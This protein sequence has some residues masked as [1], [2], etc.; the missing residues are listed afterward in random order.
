MTTKHIT[1][2]DG[3]GGGATS[4]FIKAEILSRFGNSYLNSLE[5]SSWLPE[6]HFP[7]V[8]TTDSFV[9][10]PPIF[11]GGDIGRLAISGVVNDLLASGAIPH[12][13]TL[14]LVI[15]EGFP[16]NKIHTILD[17]ILEITADIGIQVVAGDTKV[18]EKGISEISIHITGI[19]KPIHIDRNY[20][21][22]NA[23][24]K[25]KIIIT[26][27][28]GDHGFSILSFREGLGFEQRI[29]SDCAPL[30]G[31]LLPILRNFD[32]IHCM[33][34]P[35]RGGL[36]GVLLDIAE[37]SNVD[38]II[39]S[40]TIPVKPEVVFGCEMLGLDPLDLVNE[41]KMVVVVDAT[42]ASSVLSELRGHPLGRDA[43]IIG[44]IKP[45]ES[46]HGRLV[47]LDKVGA[48]VGIRPEGLAI[49]RLC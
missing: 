33:R 26:G 42:I 31:L 41:G 47:F 4:R 35:T 19:G 3:A 1:L 15:S 29:Y 23:Q 32:Q 6:A 22:S 48:R 10:D 28:V 43:K 44:E 17:S 20:A 38:V 46:S 30:A 11:P 27:T 24:I 49:P 8:I 14:A 12:Y 39:D 16:L 2:A 13:L 36:L 37:E 9:I 7:L 25:D 21:V 45:P 40:E 18:I 34:D 5:D